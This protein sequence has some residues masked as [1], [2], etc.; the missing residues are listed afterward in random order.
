MTELQAKEFMFKISEEI[1]NL[2]EAQVYCANE[3][4]LELNKETRIPSPITST[5]IVKAVKEKHEYNEVKATDVAY[6]LKQLEERFSFIEKK[7]GIDMYIIQL[8]GQEIFNAN[9]N[10]VIYLKREINNYI[11]NTSES[12]KEKEI[13]DQINNLTIKD[14]KGSIF[15]F[16]YAWAYIIINAAL[17]I[18]ITI[19]A[20]YLIKKLGLG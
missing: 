11:L 18:G 4:L 5:K 3:I 9:R 13:K 8:L 1:F 20:V 10:F 2:T 6:T 19:T 12:N 14:L 7:G 16:K 15:Q 17:T